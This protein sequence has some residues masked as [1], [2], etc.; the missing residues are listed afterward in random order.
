M[1]I[2]NAVRPTSDFGEFEANASPDTASNDTTSDDIAAG[3][4]DFFAPGSGRMF[5]YPNLLSDRFFYP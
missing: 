5:S 4:G 3:S 2:I 1:I